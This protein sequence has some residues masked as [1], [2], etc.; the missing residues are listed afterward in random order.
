MKEKKRKKERKKKKK[1]RK[2]GA[3]TPNTETNNAGLSNEETFTKCE[4]ATARKHTV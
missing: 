3:E 4:K 2:F 1:K